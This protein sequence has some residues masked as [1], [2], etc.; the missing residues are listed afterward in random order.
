MT[1]NAQ[2]GKLQIDPI[3]ANGAARYFLHAIKCIKLQAG[4]PLTPYKN[5]D[6]LSQPDIA[7]HDILQGAAVIGIDL[8]ASSGREIDSSNS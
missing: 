4:L 8:G 2:N 7:M 1:Y 5:N 6:K 3:E